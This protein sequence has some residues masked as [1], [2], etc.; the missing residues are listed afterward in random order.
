MSVKGL[1]VAVSGAAS[2][3]GLATARL[4]AQRGACLALADVDG[5]AVEA[6]AG[7]LRAAG[8][9]CVA[10]RTDV[11]SAADVETWLQSA[12]VAFG[13][14]DGAVNCAG[15]CFLPSTEPVSLPFTT[16]I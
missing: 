7:R 14:L 4:L 11:R 10:A 12:L 8:A 6:E 5:A 16:F 9:Q 1:V 13:K 2:G 15:V 3:I